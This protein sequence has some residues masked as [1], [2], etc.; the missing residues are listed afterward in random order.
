M[1]KHR[2]SHRNLKITVQHKRTW[3]DVAMVHPAAC[4]RE[5]GERKPLSFFA[6][7]HP[8]LALPCPPKVLFLLTSQI[9][10]QLQCGYKQLYIH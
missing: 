10:T 9:Y 8:L 5:L 4:I 2:G 7:A 3:T 6:N 1:E